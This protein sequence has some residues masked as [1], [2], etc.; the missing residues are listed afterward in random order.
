MKR[1]LLFSSILICLYFTMSCTKTNNVTTTI[2][3]TTVVRDTTVLRDTVYLSPKYPIA[4]HWVG[5]Y[6]LSGDLVDSFMYS[7][8][9]RDDGTVYTIGSGTNQTAGYASGP[10]TLSGVN[11]SATLTTMAGV[12]VEN[13][14][15]VTARYDSVT[16]RL[17]NGVWIDT[18]GNG[19]Q[20][21]TF[22][23][24]RVQ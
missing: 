3:D 2:R 5:S 7:F 19:G 17:Y 4:G 16:G 10:W 23:L 15:T 13:I 21:G 1:I 8:D 6:F 22:S 24:R 11:F 12:S 14:Q 9:I 18:R 20:T